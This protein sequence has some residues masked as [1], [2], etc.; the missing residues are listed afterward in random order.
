MV[1]LKLLDEMVE[2]IEINGQAQEALMTGLMTK[3]KR[4]LPDDLLEMTDQIVEDIVTA[5]LNDGETSDLDVMTADS[6]Y[7]LPMYAIDGVMPV[8]EQA[9]EEERSLDVSYYS[10]SREEF[11]IRRI[12]PYGVKRVGDLHWLIAYCH[13]REDRRVFRIDRFKTATLSE[14][15]FKPPV[16]FHIGEYFDDID[17]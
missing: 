1:G 6:S 15:H 12:D 7:A 5:T 16:D 8:I 14:A 10:M 11:S 17:P 3:L 13:L 4:A 9:I 2:A